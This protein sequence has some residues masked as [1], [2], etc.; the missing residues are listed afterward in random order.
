MKLSA[1]IYRLK[2]EARQLARRQTLP[3][4][5]ALDRLAAREGYD[6]WGHLAGSWQA[7][8]PAEVLA[9]R[10]LPGNLLALAAR[11]GEGKTV[12]GLEILAEAARKGR[13]AV[14]F[15]SECTEAAIRNSIRES[16]IDLSAVANPPAFDLADCVSARHVITKLRSFPAETLAVIDYLQVMDQLRSEAPLG[17]QVSALKAF[18]VEHKSTIVLLSQVHRSFEQTTKDLPD[19]K[20]LRT[21]NPLDLCLFDLGCFLHGGQLVLRTP[22]VR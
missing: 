10:L 11:P 4:H 3:L 18:A 9:E 7:R 8:R 16:G 5:A 17:E 19:F 13:P 21:S 14:F 6:S 1:P 22:P 20:D 2:R 12:L 15:S